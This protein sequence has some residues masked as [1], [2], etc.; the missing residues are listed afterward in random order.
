MSRPRSPADPAASALDVLALGAAVLAASAIPWLGIGHPLSHV[1]M[2]LVVATFGW[3]LI[4]PARSPLLALGA[5]DL[6]RPARFVG[7]GWVLAA[8]LLSA[9]VRYL[10]VLRLPGEGRG[11]LAFYDA[12][13]RQ[14]GVIGPE[15][16]AHW[17]LLALW[18]PLSLPVMALDGVFLAGLIQRRVGVRWNEHLGIALQALLFGLAHTFAGNEPDV[19]YGVSSLFG[20][21]CYGYLYRFYRNHWIPATFLWLH[22]VTVWAIMLTRASA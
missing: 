9:V 19:A 3:L 4:R 7:W 5:L 22:V 12:L 15:G 21:V 14:Y 1:L 13:L 20:G 17:Q 6:G 8:G 11:G 10:V 16:E 2:A 18:A